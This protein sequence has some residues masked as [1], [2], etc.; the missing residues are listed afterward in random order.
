MRMVTSPPSG[1]SATAIGTKTWIVD[2]IAPASANAG[3]RV[4]VEVK[5]YC[6]PEGWIYI[7]VG[8]K[9]DDTQ[10]SFTPLSLWMGP[11]TIGSFTSS[12][13]MPNKST[14]LHIA[15]LYYTGTEWIQDDYGYVDIALTGVPLTEIVNIFGP[16][17]ANAGELVN[18]DVR[19]K[20]TFSEALSISCATALYD[21][22]PLTF[23]P[24]YIWVDPGSIQ[25]FTASFAMP[26]KDIRLRVGSFHWTETGWVQDDYRYVDILLGEAPP[27]EGVVQLVSVNT[28]VVR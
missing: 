7:G 25:S 18:I 12:F 17:A 5:V 8:G 19:V 1:I 4:D 28:Y 10:L 6:L 2:I 23:N 9:Y 15:S 27:E 20:N 21:D 14:R 24:D 26:N 22:T 3:E 13:I 11:Y 16:I